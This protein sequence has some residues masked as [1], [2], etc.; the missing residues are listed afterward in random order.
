MTDHWTTDPTKLAAWCE[1]K[2]LRFPLI[3]EWHPDRADLPFPIV[4]RVKHWKPAGLAWLDRYAAAARDG[5]LKHG[6]WWGGVL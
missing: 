5:L 6:E 3:S 4:V 1:R 2:G